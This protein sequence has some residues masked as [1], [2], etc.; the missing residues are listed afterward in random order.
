METNR[1]TLVHTQ[2]VLN[3]HTFGKEK[4]NDSCTKISPPPLMTNNSSQPLIMV[5]IIVDFMVDW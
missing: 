3:V 4:R 2:D 1:T 5:D